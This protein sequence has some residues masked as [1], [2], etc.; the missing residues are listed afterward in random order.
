MP[1]YRRGRLPGE[2]AEAAKVE[3]PRLEARSRACS[4]ITL[5]ANLKKRGIWP[6]S[7]E[8]LV[9]E[10]ERSATA[11]LQARMSD[12]GVYNDHR[13]AADV[14]RRLKELEGPYRLAL[15]SGARRRPIS[16]PRATTAELALASHPTCEHR[17]RGGEEQLRLVLVEGS[18]RTR[19]T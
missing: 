18:R 8:E 1:G 5:D 15:G 3:L 2:A 7:F 19:R 9:A 16:T 12:P 6:K 4:E 11:R 17:A 14:G 13:E 10:L